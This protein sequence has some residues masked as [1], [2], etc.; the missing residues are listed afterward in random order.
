M[1]AARP[2]PPSTGAPADTNTTTAPITIPIPTT[3][4]N[5]TATLQQNAASTKNRTMKSVCTLLGLSADADEASVHTAVARLLN[6]GD[7]APDAL[8]TLRAAHQSLGDQNQ[9]L[10]GEQSEILLDGC[11]VKDERVRNRL[12]DGLKSLKNRAERLSYLAD[13]GY[14]PGEVARSTAG[15]G[16][17]TGVR[18]LNRRHRRAARNARPAGG[19]QRPG[20]GHQ[21]SKSHHR[22]PGPRHEV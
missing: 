2:L 3:N 5:P 22:T 15:T 20:G 19:R 10:L 6:R 9:T 7:I 8:A 14:V 18:V 12:K 17:G 4:T 16:T 21:N 1:V 11:G 13:F